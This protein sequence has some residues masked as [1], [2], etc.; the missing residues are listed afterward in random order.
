MLDSPVEEIKSR[1]NITD[2]LGDYI[3]LKKA[4][5]NYKAVCPFHS[6]K[7]PSF[8]VSPSKQIW[9]CFGC[10][11]G[12]DIFEFIKQIENV[13][14]SQALR[15]LADRAGVELKKPTVQELEL[16]KQ[17][18]VLCEINEAASRYYQKVLWESPSAGAREAMGYL[19]KRGLSDQ[20]IRNW[21]LGYSP[22]D[23]HYLENFLAKGYRKDEI[24]QAGL[25]VKK[26]DGSYFDR[27]RGRIMFPILSISGDTVGFT[28]RLIHEQPNTGKYIN[29]PETPVY[30][31]SEVIFGLYQAKNAIRKQ[32]RAILVEGNMDVISC[33]Q[34]GF[35]QTIASSGTAITLEQL[36]IVR[37]FCE[38]LLFAFD[39]DSAGGNA[40]RRA[41]ELALSLGFN[42]KIVELKAAKD[43][44]EL[45][46]KGLGIWQKAVDSAPNYIEF[47]FN[48]LFSEHDPE[49]V[50][51]KREIT[52]ELLPLIARASDPITKAHFVR[53][54]S[55]KINVAEKAVWD[56]LEKIKTPKAERPAAAPAGPK[57]DRVLI[58]EEQVLG[59]AMNL[60]KPELLKGAAKADFTGQNAELFEAL[61]QV[62]AKVSAVKKNRPEL[63][64]LIDLLTFAAENEIREQELSAEQEFARALSE[65]RR[66][67]LKAR[68]EAVAKKLTQ[69]EEAKDQESLKRLSAE[70]TEL[71]AEIAKFK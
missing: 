50:E 29:S 51:G 28:G 65:L 43:P 44:D 9:H 45:I 56:M 18:N 26:E 35:T 10:G 12:G 64:G 32:G 4:G 62:P 31:K 49:S 61:T 57:K 5:T 23:F 33:H 63:A 68:M 42:V 47:F 22:D 71:S 67:V 2:I 6:E 41:L 58:L 14:F 36:S 11:L 40:T 54:L 21:G 60:G 16:N 34:A 70:F 17:R 8:M 3:Q 38:N 27:F 19:R 48:K 30:N 53:K 46:K 1:L 25:I 7:T 15:M 55:E 39:S 20:T 13:E 24:A 66:S 52:R 69:A 37:R 59:L